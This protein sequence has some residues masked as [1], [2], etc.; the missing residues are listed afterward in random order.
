MKDENP[1]ISS[2]LLRGILSLRNRPILF[3]S[4]VSDISPTREKILSRSFMAALTTGQGM[5]KPIE[6]HSHDL[7]RYS[8][9]MLSW[10]HQACIAERDMLEILFGLNSTAGI[11]IWF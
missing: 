10:I 1:E 6:F 3:D 5:T 9:D 4:F 2:E 11:Y 7:V 8:G